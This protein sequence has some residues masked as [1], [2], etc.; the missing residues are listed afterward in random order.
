MRSSTMQRLFHYSEN[1]NIELFIPRPR[2]KRIIGGRMLEESV[3]WAID[4]WHSPVYFFPRECPRLLLWPVSG[5]IEAGISRWMGDRPPRMVAHI[6]RR[7]LQK[8]GAC[9]LYRYEFA[10]S[11][12]ETLEDAGVHV[13]T[14]ALEPVGVAPV[15][16]LH[17][18]LESADVELRTV[19]SSSRWPSRLRTLCTF[20]QYAHETHRG[21]NPPV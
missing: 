2:P 4:E 14:K 10:G 19:D 5:S 1:P 8:F 9:E 21:W 17:T 13:A 3:V 12:F 18:S 20:R 6:E 7:W 15:G 11:N 16:R